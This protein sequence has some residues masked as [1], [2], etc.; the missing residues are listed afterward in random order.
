MATTSLSQRQQN[1][2][3]S[4]PLPIEALAGGKPKSSVTLDD[5][6]QSIWTDTYFQS[7]ANAESRCC[8]VPPNDRWPA[9]AIRSS[10]ACKSGGVACTWSA[11]A[12]DDARRLDFRSRSTSATSRL[13]VLALSALVCS[14]PQATAMAECRSPTNIFLNPF[15]KESAHHRPIG[16]GAVYAD[17][18]HPSTIALLKT[19]FG[20]INSDN[21]WG[22]NVYESNP[23]DLLKTVRQAGSYD[24]GLP[25]TLRVPYGA[26]NGN[27]SDSVVVIVEG[28][29]GIAHQ[30]Y[31]WRWNNGNPTAGIHVTWHTKGPGHSHPGGP[32]VG[33]SASGVAGMFG[34]LRG[35][36]VN[37]GGYK[38]EHALQIA[39]SHPHKGCRVSQLKNKVE[40]PATSTDSY[41]ARS[42]D[43]CNGPIPYG[44]LL[45]IPPGANTAAL[46]LSEPGRRLAAALRNYGAYAVDGSDCPTL[47]ADQHVTP[48]NVL[49]LRTDM[50]KLY[51]LLRMV[52]NNKP[53]QTASGGGTSRAGNCA[54]DS[55]D[56]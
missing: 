30:F 7:T 54:F 21:G 52:L 41:C 47:R 56:R 53:A 33:T 5:T 28:G 22:A 18:N 55:P 20:N 8:T 27:K 39:L 48:A 43:L 2:T 14:L 23:S 24:K 4:T 38:I 46:G 50:R 40:W 11:G 51:P 12:P 42:P 29:T 45:A 13:I 32:R 16:N 1:A 49:A 36:E 17:R 37:T 34:L 3:A 9:R 15:N 31:Q 35:R 10:R 26:N 44:A 6:I 19:G 25:V